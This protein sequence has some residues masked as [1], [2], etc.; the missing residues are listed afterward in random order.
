M[1]SFRFDFLNIFC[2]L[3]REKSIKNSKKAIIISAKIKNI[4]MELK[5]KIK[6]M[7]RGNNRAKITLIGK[8]KIFFP[9]TVKELN[10]KKTRKTIIINK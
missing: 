5:K 10:F 1:F 3:P 6:T 9:L 7:I 2:I 4:K 8:F